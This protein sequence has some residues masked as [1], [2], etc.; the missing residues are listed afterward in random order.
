MEMKS[1][2][3]KDFFFRCPL[4]RSFKR[5]FIGNLFFV[6]IFIFI[7]FI[8]LNGHF[9]PTGYYFSSIKTKRVFKSDYVSKIF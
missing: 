2:Y 8:F 7:F 3:I 5:I 4:S 6:R 1:G 9:L